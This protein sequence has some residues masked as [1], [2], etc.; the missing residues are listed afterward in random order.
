MKIL[1]RALCCILLCSPL[2]Y[3]AGPAI[4]PKQV[5]KELKGKVVLLR[6][7]EAGDKISF[8]ASGKEVGRYQTGP[9]AYSAI[10]VDKVRLSDARLE[11]EGKRMALV[12]MKWSKDI[13]SDPQ[14]VPL[15]E[16]VEIV[17]KQ[18]PAYPEAL[19]AAIGKVFALNAA[20]VIAGLSP[21]AQKIALYSLGADAPSDGNIET[22][23]K[24]GV[25]GLT[26]PRVVYSAAPE[27]TDE[28]REKKVSGLCILSMIVDAIGRPEHIRVVSSLA[29]D[30]LKTKHPL[31]SGLQL[32]AVKAVSQYRFAPGRLH[33]T[34][35]PVAI[36]VMVNFRIY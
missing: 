16:K 34:P 3:A 24:S 7:M 6:G 1:R 25:A 29:D 33:G 2:V 8:D 9:F 31:D 18:D 21:A 32:N 28:A 27:F 15:Q 23:Y 17:I 20:D 36:Q 14:A 4:S 10:K 11:I 12:L 30:G 5:E 22:P 35:V 19:D 13:L 26:M